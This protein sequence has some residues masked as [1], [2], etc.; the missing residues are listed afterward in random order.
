MRAGQHAV[1]QGKLRDSSVQHEGV[2]RVIICAVKTLGSSI[3]KLLMGRLLM[4][5]QG[6]NV[7]V[8]F[9]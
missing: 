7:E 5:N 6:R 8:L 3:L 4:T 2:G 1:V 9:C